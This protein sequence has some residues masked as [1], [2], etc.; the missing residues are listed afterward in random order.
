MRLA[1]LLADGIRGV[2]EH[3]LVYGVSVTPRVGLSA[4]RSTTALTGPSR[5]RGR[6]TDKTTSPPRRDGRRYRVRRVPQTA[7]VSSKGF[8]SRWDVPDVVKQLHRRSSAPAIPRQGA[9]ASQLATGSTSV[10]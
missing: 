2:R 7:P 9:D 5:E 6:D 4:S 10:L 8:V 3:A 1:L